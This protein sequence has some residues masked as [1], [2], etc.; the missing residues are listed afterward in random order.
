MIYQDTIFSNNI[1]IKI[2]KKFIKTGLLFIAL[3]FVL[4][5]IGIPVSNAG[6]C[7]DICTPRNGETCTARGQTCDNFENMSTIDPIGYPTN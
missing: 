3:T 6:A 7:E 1:K 4:S 5:V 2:M